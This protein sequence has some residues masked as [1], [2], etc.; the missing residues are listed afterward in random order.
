M[1]VVSIRERVAMIFVVGGM[2]VFY[3]FVIYLI[4]FIQF[5]GIN[6]SSYFASF[7]FLTSDV[8]LTLG[9]IF[10]FYSLYDKIFFL[11]YNPVIFFVGFTLS[12]GIIF[13]LDLFFS[14][15]YIHDITKYILST[16]LAFTFF[17]D[18]NSIRSLNR[19]LAKYK[20]K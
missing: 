18:P 19:S 9:L 3:S 4:S 12:Y 11:R 2:L 10:L 8:A 16:I 7:V 1:E 17:N 15:V 13:G 5:L 6:L 14:T 20:L